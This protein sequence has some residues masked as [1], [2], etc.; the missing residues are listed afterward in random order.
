MQ[1]NWQWCHQILSVMLTSSS[2]VSVLLTVCSSI[3]Q[4]HL[5][6]KFAIACLLLSVSWCNHFSCSVPWQILKKNQITNHITQR[7][8]SSISSQL[9]MVQFGKLAGIPLRCS[10]QMAK[11]HAN[12]HVWRG[13]TWWWKWWTSFLWKIGWYWRL[14]IHFVIWISVGSY[15]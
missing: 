1:T 12:Q 2:S 4:Q 7:S 11:I 13:K 5:M 6:L 15:E 9:L 3:S 10:V 8:R 14:L